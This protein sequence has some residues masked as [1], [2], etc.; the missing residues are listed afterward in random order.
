M[1]MQPRDNAHAHHVL[2]AFGAHTMT[3][4]PHVLMKP[5]WSVLLWIS[6]GLRHPPTRC[7][8]EQVHGPASQLL[9]QQVASAVQGSLLEP[10]GLVSG[11]PQAGDKH[12]VLAHAASVLVVAAV[13]VL[14]VGSRGGGCVVAWTTLQHDG[15]DMGMNMG[16]TRRRGQWSTN[17][18]LEVLPE[19]C[20]RGG[21]GR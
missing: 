15:Y 20:V 17:I 16:V 4:S 18:S 10:V 7:V 11:G 21:V 6:R 13:G 1:A 12:L 8:H 5:K 9:H 3:R 14:P 19:G 2:C